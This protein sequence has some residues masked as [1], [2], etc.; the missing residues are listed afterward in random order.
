MEMNRTSWMVAGS[1][2]AI[3]LLFVFQI[4][5]LQ[6]SASLI[7][8]QFDQKVT[9][10]LC[11]A[12]DDL[13]QANDPSVQIKLSCDKQITE[14]QSNCLQTNVDEMMLS[15]AL[16]RAMERYDIA[17]DFRFHV[18]EQPL[19][20][21][22]KQNP[23]YCTSMTSFTN[24]NRAVQVQFSGK[25]QYIIDELGLM[26]GS[27]IFILLFVCVLF[28]LTLYRLV[29][30]RRLNAVS[31]AFF[32]N[33][34]HEFRTPLTNIKL[35]TRMLEKRQKDE[36]NTPFIGIIQSEGDRLF[37]QV[38]RMLQV[39]NLER[40]NYNMQFEPINLKSLV[41]EVCQEMQIQL[42]SRG[43]ALAF[44][45]NVPDSQITGDRLHLS[46]A[47]RNIVDNAIKYCENAPNLKLELQQNGQKVQLKFADNGIGI[48]E[49]EC[50]RIF[51][52]FHR[53]QNGNVY[54][55]NGF[56]LGL[57]Y[58]KKV[59]EMHRGQIA[60][61]SCPGEGSIFTIQLPLNTTSHDS[62]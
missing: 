11:N 47:I 52:P 31:I 41:D 12:V 10:A 13:K 60:L 54:N 38:E 55:Q 2:L 20:C 50:K 35:A 36:A 37:E 16:N 23:V 7:E 43:G 28:A 62:K 34:A 5:W 59:V 14:C 46:N 21:I 3:V 17:L 40:G 9:M 22:D 48:D 18:I 39:A 53:V 26:A 44:E 42:E 6:H 15:R 29:Q 8:E 24:D 19:F 49:Q 30:Q 61:N 4:N 27:S 58:V 1:A 32:N 25:E 51:E 56:G 45:S 33:M 57:A